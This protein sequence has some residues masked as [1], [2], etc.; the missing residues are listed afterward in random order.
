L[1]L[2]DE[3]CRLARS[4]GGHSARLVSDPAE[5]ALGF[6]RASRAETTGENAMTFTFALSN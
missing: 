3:L 6:Y 1:A 4:L 2:L 5:E